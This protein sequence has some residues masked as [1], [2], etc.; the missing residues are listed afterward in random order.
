MRRAMQS[1]KAQGSIAQCIPQSCC[2][3]MGQE[4]TKFSLELMLLL[5]GKCNTD[6]A[7]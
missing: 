3:A 4:I 1:L 7:M 5:V 2:A 6:D